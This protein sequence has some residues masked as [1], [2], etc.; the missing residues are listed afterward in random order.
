M[1]P[2]KRIYTVEC[3]GSES[4]EW[5]EFGTLEAKTTKACL[6]FLAW[7]H[8]AHTYRINGIEYVSLTR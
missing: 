1:T 3:K 7:C 2:T 5:Y 8:K 4:G 6:K